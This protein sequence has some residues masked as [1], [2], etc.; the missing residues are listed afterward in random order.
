MQD[1]VLNHFY[2]ARVAVIAISDPGV[3]RRVVARIR[4]ICH[5]VYVIVRTRMMRD[6]SEFYKLGANSVDS[7]QLLPVEGT[8]KLHSPILKSTL[9]LAS[10]LL[11]PR[12]FC[13]FRNI[14]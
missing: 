8:S 13:L 3:S 6:V 2:R 12:S 14:L 9:I 10:G 7:F 4:A 5:S 11:I 1:F